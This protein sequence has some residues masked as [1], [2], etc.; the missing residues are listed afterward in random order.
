MRVLSLFSILIISV[1][2][3][4]CVSISVVTD[5]DRQADFSSFK[6]FAFFKEGVDRATISDL[7]KKRILRAIE[8]NLSA[9]GMVL[10]EEPDFL[11][12]IFTKERE[13]VNIYNNYPYWGWSMGWGPFW[14][15]NYHNISSNTE[16]V[17]YIEII[18]AKKKDLVWQ[19][20]GVGYIPENVE[21]KEETI[22]KF[23]NAILEKYPPQKK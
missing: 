12:N 2:A 15:M 8:Q 21:D 5:Y 13:S 23:V 6:S 14:G 7:D 16:G 9:K 19:G 22:V 4:S 10:S 17:L 11:V 3:I 1:A 18:N 20:K